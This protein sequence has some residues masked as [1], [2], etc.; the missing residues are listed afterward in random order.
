M[1]TD[2]ITRTERDWNR[3]AQEVLQIEE[4]GG[5]IIYGF[6]SELACLRLLR[7]YRDSKN[8]RVGFSEARQSWFC[9]LTF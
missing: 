3:V 5:T 8:F 7:Y 6:G 4:V 1:T 2:T 9:S